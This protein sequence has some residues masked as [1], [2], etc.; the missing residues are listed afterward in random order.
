MKLADYSFFVFDCDG[1]IL[2]SNAIKTNA[3]R[4]AL[5]AE[6]DADV[7]ALVAYHLKNGGITRQKKFEY[8]FSSIQNRPD[9]AKVNQASDRFATICEAALLDAG[10]VPGVDAFLRS[11]QQPAVVVTGGNQ[12]EV[13]RVL[14]HKG[15]GDC[16]VSIRGN[17][18]SKDDNMAD[19]R[20]EG[21]FDGRGVFFGD[22]LLDYELSQKYGMDFVFISGYSDWAQGGA[23]CTARGI[24]SYSS[25]LEIGPS[26]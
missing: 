7:E 16:F 21:F 26:E 4:Q 15:I 10:L 9:P 8:F 24:R 12:D 5:S 1:V 2:D 6:P 23:H 19:L 13:K 18:V 22:A 25:F 3:F 11:K 20:A 17:P 14:K